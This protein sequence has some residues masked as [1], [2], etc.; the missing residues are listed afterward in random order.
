M[1]RGKNSRRIAAPQSDWVAVWL[2]VASTIALLPSFSPWGAAQASDAPA[3]A[4]SLLAL[5]CAFLLPR[6][7]E[8]SG[9]LL[10]RLTWA[11]SAFLAWALVSA[12]VSGRPFSA[13][14]GAPMTLVGWIALFLCGAIVLGGMQKR[15]EL[16][17]LLSRYYAPG[18]IWIQAA[19]VTGQ[20]I[21]GTQGHGTMSNSSFLGAVIVLLL[22][23]AAA[24]L[25]ERAD[26]TV[27]VWQWGS[28]VA[29]FA[30][31]AASGSRVALA[32]ALLWA[33]WRGLARLRAAAD[34]R[35]RALIVGA[36]VVV[37]ATLALLSERFAA[38][39]TTISSLSFSLR[40]RIA[41]WQPAFDATLLRP[42]VGYGP[43]GYQAAAPKVMTAAA[44]MINPNLGRVS[45]DPHMILLWVLVSTGFVGLALFGWTAAEI[46]RNWWLQRGAKSSPAPYAWGIGL[47]AL[48][49]MTSPAAMQTLPIMLLVLAC[50]LRL[51]RPKGEP[52][53]ASTLAQAYGIAVVILA[54]LF[55]TYAA[56]SLPLGSL[57]R[58]GQQAPARLTQAVADAWHFDPFLYYL[59]SLSWGY[60][61]IADP[62]VAARQPDLVAIRRAV[63]LEPGNSGYRIELARTLSFYNAPS[64]EVMAAYRDAIAAFP[65]SPEAHIGLG[66]YLLDA[67]DLKAA[68]AQLDTA[69]QVRPDDRGVV[70]FA[71][72]YYKKAGDKLNIAKYEKILAGLPPAPS[73]VNQ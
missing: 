15:T 6:G 38:N 32:V 10:W 73:P 41:H 7:A 24:G 22:P 11:F 36:G 65:L 50:S 58:T 57:D 25:P 37:L 51:Q 2:L 60:D 8:A 5:T 49:A 67:G 45:S 46:G 27:R 18:F 72:A 34:L 71:I 29:G 31:L 69:L 39:E 3:V 13:M 9:V 23:V 19:F 16:R 54:V 56:S 40:D 26:T 4:F 63:A 68:K 48:V 55:G 47:Y 64:A 43:D 20:M 17:Q 42:L 59:A 44:V 35:V 21:S 66:Q 53:D 62:N 33:A 28:L 52:R 70:A 1:A 12:A 14:F 61:A 30:T